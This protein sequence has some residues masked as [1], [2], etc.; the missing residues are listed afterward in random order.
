MA[1][2]NSLR[3]YP[4]TQRSLEYRYHRDP[5]TET[6]TNYPTL[7]K[8][9]LVFT[10]SLSLKTQVKHSACYGHPFFLGG[11]FH[12]SLST[13]PSVHIVLGIHLH[14]T[15][16][17]ECTPKYPYTQKNMSRD[18]DLLRDTSRYWALYNT[19]FTVHQ[20]RCRRPMSHLST[21]NLS[22]FTLRHGSAT[23]IEPPCRIEDLHSGCEASPP[24][25]NTR[26]TGLRL[27]YPRSPK[28]SSIPA[29]RVS[30]PYRVNK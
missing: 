20:L 10:S 3:K 14:A 15:Q 11:I 29:E 6:A 12:F 28:I 22:T 4:S 24:P 7:V 17:E 21:L 19:S 13:T 30:L 16:Q 23:K 25:S 18:F 2:S 1:G 27:R 8:V 26:S 5:W 9:E